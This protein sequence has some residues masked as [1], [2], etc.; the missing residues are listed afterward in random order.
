MTGNDAFLLSRIEAQGWNA[1][2]R[3]MIGETRTLDD[4]RIAKLNPHVSDP[5]RARWRTGFKNAM[6]PA[7]MKFSK[8]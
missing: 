4:A 7:E 2:Q 6:G 8:R 3:V 5:E 1:A